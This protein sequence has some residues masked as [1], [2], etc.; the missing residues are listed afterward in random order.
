MGCVPEIVNS[1]A[2]L[3]ARLAA[4]RRAERTIG[5]V[6][7]MGALHAG[8]LAL[9]AE[10]RRRAD[11]TVVSIFVNPTQFGDH[12]DLELYPRTL[13]TDV[14]QLA[15]FGVDLV[16]AP[17]VEQMYPEGP[18]QVTVHAGPAGERFEGRSRPGHFDGMLTVVAKLFGIVQPDLAVFGEKDAQQLHLVRR[19]V[20]DLDMPVQI[21]GVPTVREHD[22][23]A[24][25]SRNVRI[26]DARRPDALA[27][28]RALAAASRASDAG[29]EAI[30]AAAQAVLHADRGVDLD[31]LAVVDPE[32]FL[33][34]ADSYVGP[35]LVLIA[36]RV[37]DVR[38]IDNR[39][40]TV[41]PRR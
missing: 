28:S 3:R 1:I 35:A 18:T 12:N 38:L 16:F 10:A 6:P 31:Y 13:E 23:L 25:S 5:F 36:A 33:P 7:T 20:A 26:E 27:L 14:A 8:H 17:T 15:A 32:S 11:V 34:L 9:V 4:E 37:G 24:L 22:G 40:V 2:A 30:I 41:A 29:V 39:R 21:I 19:L